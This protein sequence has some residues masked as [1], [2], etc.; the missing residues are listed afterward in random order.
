LQR[1][2]EPISAAATMV[3]RI[4]A[5]DCGHPSL[6]DTRVPDHYAPAWLSTRAGW[7]AFLH[8]YAGFTKSS[9]RYES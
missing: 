1:E 6:T 4:V 8:T 7:R 3:S 5:N 9:G 2:A